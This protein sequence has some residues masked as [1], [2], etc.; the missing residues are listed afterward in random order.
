MKTRKNVLSI[1]IL[2]IILCIGIVIGI[3]NNGLQHLT[4][5]QWTSA[6]LPL[7]QWL[8]LFLGIGF[9]FGM[10]AML[11]HVISLQLQRNRLLR[12]LKKVKQS[13]A[14]KF[15]LPLSADAS[16]AE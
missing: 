2:I 7:Y 12:E 6:E 9:I 11:R 15:V 10:I 3:D 5:L 4:V 1:L 13:A 16:K 14:E 8:L